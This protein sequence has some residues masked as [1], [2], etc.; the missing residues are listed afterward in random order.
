MERRCARVQ[1]QDGNDLALNAG[2]RNAGANVEGEAGMARVRGANAA[3]AASAV[4]AA[5]PAADAAAA[6]ALEL[7]PAAVTD[8]NSFDAPDDPPPHCHRAHFHCHR[9]H[10]RPVPPP[11]SA[12]RALPLP[13]KDRQA[14]TCMRTR[15]GL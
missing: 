10:L 3:P 2:A 7:L 4:A 8:L 15:T 5:A 11:L 6:A 14:K 1:V 13:K 9:A 12:V